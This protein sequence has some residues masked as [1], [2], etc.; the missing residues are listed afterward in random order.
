MTKELIECKP[1]LSVDDLPPLELGL[2]VEYDERIGLYYCLQTVKE[3]R[4]V[5]YWEDIGKVF[6]GFT[7][8]PNV[9]KS[10]LIGIK[11]ARKEEEI[12]KLKG[13]TI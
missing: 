9:N 13:L 5:K 12:R 6:L 3:S 10:M 8:V 7:C 1:S 11:V 2:F 4:D